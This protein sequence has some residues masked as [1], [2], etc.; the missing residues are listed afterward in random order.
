MLCYKTKAKHLASK[1][2]GQNQV[3]QY[4]ENMSRIVIE[5]MRALLFF[6]HKF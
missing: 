2:K 1:I 3:G 6:S 5:S 4:S